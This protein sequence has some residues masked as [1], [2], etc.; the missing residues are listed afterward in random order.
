VRLAPPATSTLPAG[1]S[2]GGAL[3]QP[4]RASAAAVRHEARG[5]P[6]V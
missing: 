4:H 6:R 5:W 3:R 1:C 2:D